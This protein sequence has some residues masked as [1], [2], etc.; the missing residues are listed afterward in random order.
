MAWNGYSNDGQRVNLHKH[1]KVH[2]VVPLVLSIAAIAIVIILAIVAFRTSLNDKE[3]Q[4]STNYMK[5]LQIKEVKPSLPTNKTVSTETKSIKIPVPDCLRKSFASMTSEEKH[6]AMIYWAQTVKDGPVLDMRIRTPPPLLSNTVQNAILSYSEPGAEVIPMGYI[7]DKSAKEAIETEIVFNHDDPDD[8]LEKKQFV[9]E[10]LADLKKFMS[11][12]GRAMEFFQR[13][14]DRQSLEY[15]AV[16]SCREE[17]LKYR[18]E[19]DEEGAKLALETY[20][21]YLRDKGI[22]EIHMATHSLRERYFSNNPQ[23]ETQPEE[24][25]NE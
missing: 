4:N 23:L 12:G 5:A 19:G 1:T 8:V 25:N 16:A 18:R 3:E 6:E 2:G 21:K 7:S 13:L 11:G 20:N 15:T 22:P 9:K 17:V 14:D 24:Y 10:T